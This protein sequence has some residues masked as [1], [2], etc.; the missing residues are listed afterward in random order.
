VAS[1]TGSSGSTPDDTH[2]EA[3]A[4]HIKTP[5]G[6]PPL[7]LKARSG[8][9]DETHTPAMGNI[10][11]TLDRIREM[12]DLVLLD[13][14]DHSDLDEAEMVERYIAQTN[15]ELKARDER[16][17]QMQAA[18]CALKQAYE[19]SEEKLKQCRADLIEAV[20]M[21]KPDETRIDGALTTLIEATTQADCFLIIDRGTAEITHPIHR[22]EQFAIT[23]HCAAEAF[24]AL[25]TIA[26]LRSSAKATQAAA[27]PEDITQ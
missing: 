8:R 21:I 24:A 5:T 1:N 3:A 16:I 2:V 12:L 17:E 22:P 25:A 27:Q 9:A 19:D 15:T 18:A 23:P 20:H 10:T 7:P 4:V 26:R 6:N 11:D 13:D 14:T